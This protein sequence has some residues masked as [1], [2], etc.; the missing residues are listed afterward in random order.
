[1]IRSCSKDSFGHERKK[2]RCYRKFKRPRRISSK[3]AVYFR[4]DVVEWQQSLNSREI[5]DRTASFKKFWHVGRLKMFNNSSFP[6]VL[7]DVVKSIDIFYAG[8]RR[9]VQTHCNFRRFWLFKEA[10]INA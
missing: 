8:P 4:T 1:M 5:V 6:A 2:Q 7:R 3:G 10:R 9:K